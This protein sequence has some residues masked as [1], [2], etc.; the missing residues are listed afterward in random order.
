MKRI[1]S[2]NNYL[3]PLL[4]IEVVSFALIYNFAAGVTVIISFISFIL[5]TSL[6]VYVNRLGKNR[7]DAFFKKYGEAISS[8]NA[9]ERMNHYEEK[10]TALNDIISNMKKDFVK[11]SNSCEFVDTYKGFMSVTDK[12]L[13]E[14]ESAKIFKVN[15]NEFLGNVAHELRTPIFAI[16]LSLET[17]ADGAIN[18]PS[19]NTE[20]LKKAERQTNR[21]K[22]LVD[23][24]IHIS[25]LEEGMRLSKR[26]FSINQLIKETIS[27]LSEIAEKK[28]LKLIFETTLIDESVVIADRERIKQVLVN[29]ID[30]STK[31]TPDNGYVIITTKPDLDCI[32]VSVKDSGVGI[33]KD[34]LPR[35]FERFYR[36]D[37]TRSRDNG[38]SG[39]GLSIV[40]HIMELHNS[41]I[42][43]TSNEGE[44]SEFKFKL[45]L[46]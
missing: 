27:E 33:P 22:E 6:H 11:Y 29:L 26:Y 34:D 7:V 40:K 14:L 9:T 13:S 45:F 42:T 38:G 17:L 35:I 20:F 41:K 31:Y 30:N 8:L 44:G 2:N 16:Q 4:F 12:L 32:I 1:L 21:L 37:K 39:L 46:K 18:D 24:L 23:D 10:I 36:V 5:I 19:V 15:R 25:K 3:L 43:V 28:K